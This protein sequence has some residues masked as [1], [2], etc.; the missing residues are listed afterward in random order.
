[1]GVCLYLKIR[2]LY[3]FTDFISNSFRGVAMMAPLIVVMILFQLR[4]DAPVAG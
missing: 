4:I 2:S 3:D 1:M